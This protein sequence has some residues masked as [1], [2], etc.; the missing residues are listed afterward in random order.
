[1]PHDM[2]SHAHIEQAEWG[3]KAKEEFMQTEL[4]HKSSKR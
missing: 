4:M 3:F 2:T 1:M